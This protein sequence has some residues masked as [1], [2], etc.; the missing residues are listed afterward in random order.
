MHTSYPILEKPLPLS[1][2]MGAWFMM[3]LKES[4]L[5]VKLIQLRPLPAIDLK[6]FAIMPGAN[7]MGGKR[8]E[9]PV[10]FRVFSALDTLGDVEILLE[11]ARKTSQRLILESAAS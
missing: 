1:L 11:S 3:L 8:Y 4:P 10:G 9:K 7:W 2:I 6:A 5:K